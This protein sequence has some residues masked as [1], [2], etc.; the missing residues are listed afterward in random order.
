MTPITPCGAVPNDA[1]CSYCLEIHECRLMRESIC[2]GCLREFLCPAEF[3]R[4]RVEQGMCRGRE[5]RG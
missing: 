1:D 5:L 2:K 3:K 4:K